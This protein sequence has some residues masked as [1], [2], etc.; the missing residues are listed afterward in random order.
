MIVVFLLW[1][2]ISVQSCCPTCN[3]HHPCHPPLITTNIGL[4][5]LEITCVDNECACVKDELDSC[6]Y[7]GTWVG[8]TSI[9]W[10]DG[11]W[12]E[13]IRVIRTDPLQASAT[14]R[15]W[16][17]RAKCMGHSIINIE[18]AVLRVHRD[19][20][21][22][23][24]QTVSH[25]H[26]ETIGNVFYVRA[27]SGCSD[28]RP[29]VGQTEMFFQIVLD[30]P[31]LGTNLKLTKCSVLTTSGA[32]NVLSPDCVITT[33]TLSTDGSGIHHGVFSLNQTR[34]TYTAFWDDESN[35]PYH[36]I[37]CMYGIYNGSHLSERSYMIADPN[38]HGILW[39]EH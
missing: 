18:A 32:C 36:N 37:Q 8:N 22:E 29:I 10:S 34:L 23:F 19:V 21:V 12:H 11:R 7:G 33:N 38:E 4:N 17:N 15:W 31:V 20:L 3:C 14:I 39:H 16:D 27:T 5:G 2:V 35:S 6:T 1:C 30:P 24:E 13:C 26:D 28:P 9:K 25:R